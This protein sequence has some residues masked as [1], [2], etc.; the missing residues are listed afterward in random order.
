MFVFLREC[1]K[2]IKIQNLSFSTSKKYCYR[3]LNMVPVRHQRRT[4]KTLLQ[5]NI[6]AQ[7]HAMR[8]YK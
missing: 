1:I 8:I 7:E 4:W 2:T 6:V 3:S 5:Y